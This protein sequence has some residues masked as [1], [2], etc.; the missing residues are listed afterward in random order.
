MELCNVLVGLRSL[1]YTEPFTQLHTWWFQQGDCLNA[2]VGF[3]L[4]A[5]SFFKESIQLLGRT[6]LMF[7]F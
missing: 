2:Y 3:V 5:W 6:V 4:C 1:G 7:H